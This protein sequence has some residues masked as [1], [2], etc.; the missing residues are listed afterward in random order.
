MEGLPNLYG[1]KEWFY[2]Q[3]FCPPTV[4]PGVT[5]P[6]LSPDGVWGGLVPHRTQ[7]RVGRLKVSGLLGERGPEVGS[8]G[9]LSRGH[10]KKITLG[11]CKHQ[12]DGRA[13]HL[14]ERYQGLDSLQVEQ[15]PG[16][17]MKNALNSS[18]IEKN[19]LKKPCFQ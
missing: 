19:R 13:T 7:W 17:L 4:R 16:H 15:G 14:H 2:G 1:A 6:H 10:L 8:T 18:K 12:A 9:S 11:W 3:N 5:P